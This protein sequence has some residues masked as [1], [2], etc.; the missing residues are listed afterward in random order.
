MSND[1]T[2]IN[3]GTILQRAGE[4]NKKAYLVKEGL[5]RS[6][7]IDDQGKVHTFMFAPEG[8]LLADPETNVNNKATE[9]F[10]EALE[11]SLVRIVYEPVAT[12]MP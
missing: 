12:P 5:L 8:W 7:I 4:L 2:I 11:K 6:Y 10:V 9:L 1:Y 3:K